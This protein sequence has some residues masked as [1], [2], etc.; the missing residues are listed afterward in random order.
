M[1][2]KGLKNH[3]VS[4]FS[5]RQHYSIRITGLLSLKDLEK[6]LVVCLIVSSRLR[7]FACLWIWD[8]LTWVILRTHVEVYSRLTDCFI[9][10]INFTS[11]A[12][13]PP[14]PYAVPYHLLDFACVARCAR[15]APVKGRGDRS[16]REITPGQGH[17]LLW[18]HVCLFS[19]PNHKATHRRQVLPVC[20][21]ACS[22][23]V[24]FF[25]CPQSHTSLNKSGG[26]FSYLDLSECLCFTAFF[27]L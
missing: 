12:V 11:G 14:R 25:Q 2:L 21:D 20:G 24:A 10:S 16:P 19:P 1:P 6:P 7:L 15:D 27:A 9:S 17:L 4:V 22:V 8:K 23:C 3:F 18:H 26:T 5:T 13:F